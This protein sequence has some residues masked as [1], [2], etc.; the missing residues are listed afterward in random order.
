MEDFRDVRIFFSLF[1]PFMVPIFLTYLSV[2]SVINL[3][4][5][6]FFLYCLYMLL[7]IEG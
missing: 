5:D 2:F 1:C 3:L 7:V 4:T 6:V